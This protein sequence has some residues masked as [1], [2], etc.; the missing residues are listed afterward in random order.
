MFPIPYLFQILSSQSDAEEVERIV[1]ECMLAKKVS[2]INLREFA[3]LVLY[4]HGLLDITKGTKSPL[5][6]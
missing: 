5:F 1:N 3:R 2:S 4:K 6:D